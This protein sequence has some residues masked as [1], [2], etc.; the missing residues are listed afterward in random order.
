MTQ[1]NLLKQLISD[2]RNGL[3][4]KEEYDKQSKIIRNQIEI[5]TYSPKENNIDF[6]IFDNLVKIRNQMYDEIEEENVIDLEP[7]EDGNFRPEAILAVIRGEI[8]HDIISIY[9][10]M[11]LDRGYTLTP[12]GTFIYVDEDED[13]DKDEDVDEDDE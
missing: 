4:S 8:Q 13:E 12:D 3:I 1:I 2:S 9:I 10:D 5:Q 11:M 7:D 6:K